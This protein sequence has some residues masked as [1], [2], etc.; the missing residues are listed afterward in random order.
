[1]RFEQFCGQSEN[2]E[3]QQERINVPSQQ[4]RQAR[5]DQQLPETALLHEYNHP[6]KGQH[7]R[8]QIDRNFVENLVGV[9]KD[10]IR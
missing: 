9:V 6:V 1:M 10:I 2:D 4:Q 8:K 3:W 7:Y 5:L